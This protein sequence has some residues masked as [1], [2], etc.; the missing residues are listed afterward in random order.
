MDDPLI[1][2]PIPAPPSSTLNEN[3]NRVPSRL[4]LFESRPLSQGE[5]A[6]AYPVFG[7]AIAYDKVRIAQGPR[8]R[9]YGAMAPFRHTIIHG[10]WPAAQDFASAPLDEQGWFIHEMAHVFQAAR[11]VVLPLSKLR[12]MGRKAYRFELK[13]GDRFED[14]NIEQQAEIA[15]ALFLA[16]MGAK[17]QAVALAALEAVWPVKRP[18]ATL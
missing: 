5:I 11:G 9:L 4:R 1:R 6:L 8:W 17:G 12:A 16:R 14:F 2:E 7:D 15:R 13:A 10:A 18:T 3:G